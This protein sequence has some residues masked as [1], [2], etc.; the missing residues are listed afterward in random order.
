[1]QRG[2]Q[3][4]GSSIIEQAN[5]SIIQEFKHE[6]R[7]DCSAG[8]S[9]IDDT[10]RNQIE[11]S[12]ATFQDLQVNTVSHDE[13]IH[14]SSRDL[15]N[16]TNGYT[17]ASLQH[18]ILSGGAHFDVP[19]NIPFT[20]MVSG[21]LPHPIQSNALSSFPIGVDPT[22]SSDSPPPPPPIPDNSMIDPSVP[23]PPPPPAPAGIQYG[24]Y[25]GMGGGIAS[26]NSGMTGGMWVPGVPTVMSGGV[27]PKQEMQLN[28]KV[29]S[30]LRISRGVGTSISNVVVLP[31]SRK[32]RNY[33]KNNI[34]SE[35]E[36]IQV[37]VPVN[38]KIPSAEDVVSRSKAIF[39]SGPNGLIQPGIHTSFTQFDMAVPE[40]PGAESSLVAGGLPLNGEV[41]PKYEDWN[42]KLEPSENEPYQPT[43]SQTTMDDSTERSPIKLSP[44]NSTVHSPDHIISEPTMSNGANSESRTPP[45][46]TPPKLAPSKLPH[47]EMVDSKPENRCD[48][49]GKFFANSGTLHNHRLRHQGIRRFQCQMC[50]MAFIFRSGLQRHERTHSVEKPFQCEECPK[51]FREKSNLKIHKRV[52]TGEKPFKC[53]FCGKGFTQSAG[54]KCHENSRIH[55][56]DK[57]IDVGRFSHVDMAARAPAPGLLNE[58]WS[59]ERESVTLANVPRASRNRPQIL[60]HAHIQYHMSQAH[61][62]Q[63]NST[64]SATGVPTIYPVRL[65]SSSTVTMDP[66]AAMYMIPSGISAAA[67]LPPGVPTGLPPGVPAGLP[68]G[69]SAGLPPGVPASFPADI[70][71]DMSAALP[72]GMSTGLPAGPEQQWAPPAAPNVISGSVTLA[73]TS[74][75]APAQ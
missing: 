73:S 11:S 27:W 48:D 69:V 42:S 44:N 70:P 2:M 6:T 51:R 13:N 33:V 75:S 39:T 52:H 66:A 58:G 55:I 5:G 34:V 10:S 72:I 14:A 26:M 65:P 56:W 19:Q 43:D 63:V 50:G 32:K 29:V 35:P 49:C 40:I 71:P 47:E 61:Q 17:T 54:L 22:L 12:A 59:A 24:M 4:F 36:I 68:P 37:Y 46:L 8:G 57:P 67:G 60:S 38:R 25:P 16:S 7:L 31:H 74:M 64:D 9:I 3:S 1:M 23:P 15:M 41:Q 45:E 20:P 30:A 21:G 18:N 53:R 62:V 28:M